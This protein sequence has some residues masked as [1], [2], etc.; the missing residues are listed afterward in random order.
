[1]ETL[2]A[3]SLRRAE[4]LA[5]A[6]WLWFLFSLVFLVLWWSLVAGWRF[7]HAKVFL[8][9]EP[10]LRRMTHWSESKP[11][12]KRKWLSLLWGVVSL[13]SPT[14]PLLLPLPGCPVFCFSISFSST[15]STSCSWAPALINRKIN[16]C[17][18][19]SKLHSDL[20][21]GSRLWGLHLWQERQTSHEL[22]LSNSSRSRQTRQHCR[23]D[24]GSAAVGRIYAGPPWKDL[25]PDF[26]FSLDSPGVVRLSKYICHMLMCFCGVDSLEKSP[27]SRQ[28]VVYWLC[29]PRLRVLLQLACI[30]T[31]CI[32]RSTFRS[33]NAFKWRKLFIWLKLYCVCLIMLKPQVRRCSKIFCKHVSVSLADRKLYLFHVTDQLKGFDRQNKQSRWSW[34]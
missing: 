34:E 2:L 33:L 10:Q 24:S 8:L 30:C 19:D 11:R 18:C 9:S 20:E 15:P 27:T 5:W 1:M 12:E 26:L 7:T 29:R 3:L 13:W 23:C 32:R 25:L 21:K 22:L 14:M 16:V 17:V 31:I 6:A 4:R 28:C